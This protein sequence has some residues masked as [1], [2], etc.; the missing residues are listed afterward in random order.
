MIAIASNLEALKKRVIRFFDSPKRLEVKNFVRILSGSGEVL[1]FGG[2]LRDI[3]LYGG[4]VFNSDIDLVIDC[5]P[6]VL[7]R[8]FE[9]RNALSGR[10]NFGGYRV[11]VGGWSID[12]WPLRETWAFA[13]G[14]VDFVDRRSLLLTTITNWDSIAYS[15]MDNALIADSYYMEGLRRRELDVILVENPNRLGALLRV[16]K[17]IFDKQVEVLL[18]KALMYLKAG[19]SEFSSADL[20]RSQINA[21]NKIYFSEEEIERFRKEIYTLDPSLFGRSISLKGTTFDIGF[22]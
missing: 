18:P 5:S 16:L 20:F 13:S 1:V 17:L 9:E 14:N 12:V 15:F 22:I 11:K 7:F 6:E 10:N 3:A 8:F 4:S 19:L 2:L 21:F